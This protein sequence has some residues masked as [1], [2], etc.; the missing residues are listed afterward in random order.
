MPDTIKTDNDFLRDKIDLRAAHLPA[1][2]VRVLD[3]FSGRGLLWRGVEKITKRK[4][5]SLPIDVRDDIG[6]H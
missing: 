1:G 3:C 6:F 2:D 4:I 5:V